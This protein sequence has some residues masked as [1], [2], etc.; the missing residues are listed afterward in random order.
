[1]TQKS[2][3]SLSIDKMVRMMERLFWGIYN[4]LYTMKE[5]KVKKT[6]EPLVGS[7]RKS[8]RDEILHFARFLIRVG[9]IFSGAVEVFVVSHHDVARTLIPPL[10]YRLT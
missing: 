7:G 9:V 10:K 5:L 8:L 2:K 3:S 6:P 4:I 1:M